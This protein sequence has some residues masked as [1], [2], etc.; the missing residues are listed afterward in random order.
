MT[1]LEEKLK[2]NVNDAFKAEQEKAKRVPTP[3]RIGR[4]KG[5]YQPPQP[6]EGRYWG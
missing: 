1:D 6:P 4:A 5:E 2:Q 3:W